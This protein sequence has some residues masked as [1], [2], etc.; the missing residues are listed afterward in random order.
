M[1][2]HIRAAA[3]GALAGLAATLAMSTVFAAGQR[4]GQFRA[5][6]PELVIKRATSA[7]GPL[8]R[9]N[10]DERE[11]AWRVGHL[12]FGIGVGLL[13]GLTR[14]SLPLSIRGPAGGALLGGALWLLNYGALA[15]ALG[16]LPPIPRDDTGRQA[17]NALAHVVYGLTLAVLLRRTDR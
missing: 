6:P 13:Y 9:L 14:N 4:A 5:Y 7:D 8:P 12:D 10:P 15:P 16:L 17:T 2:N 3:A 1:G 11:V